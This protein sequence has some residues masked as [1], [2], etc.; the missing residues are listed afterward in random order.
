MNGQENEF[1]KVQLKVIDMII[2]P[3]DI[4]LIEFHA[5][6]DN[7]VAKF[8][9]RDPTDM[10][11]QKGGKQEKRSEYGIQDTRVYPDLPFT[12][13]SFPLSAFQ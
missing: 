2:S 1:S 4:F 13:K 12:G 3:L 11:E 8:L 5:T 9:L 6:L 10:N 7:L